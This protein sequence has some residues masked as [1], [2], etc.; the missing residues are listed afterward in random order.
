MTTPRCP[1]YGF[2]WPDRT[3]DLVDVGGN[4]CGLD[5]DLCGPCKM[6]L[7]NCAPDYR[8]CETVSAAKAFLSVATSRIRF[9]PS[10]SVEGVSFEV[11]TGRVM[12]RTG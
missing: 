5:L 10:N 2:R 4:E 11:W 6:E 3:T 9:F 12:L 8:Y 7:Q 1:F